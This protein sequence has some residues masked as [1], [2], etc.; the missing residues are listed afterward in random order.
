MLLSGDIE[1]I[2]EI[3]PAGFHISLRLR[4]GV[5]ISSVN[6]YPKIWV[7]KYNELGLLLYDPCIRWAF[8]NVGKCRWSSLNK[9]DSHN[10]LKLATQYDLKY[11]VVVSHKSDNPQELK[12]IAT[13]ARND[14]EFE[15]REL[16]YLERCV[17]RFHKDCEEPKKVTKAEIE[18]LELLA[19]GFLLKEIGNILDVSENAIKQRLHNVR[20]K[21]KVK[22]SVQAAL[23]A[24]Q[25]GII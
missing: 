22:T 23:R 20:R 1:H 15:E 9:C 16:S 24:H 21:L 25:F 7:D 17:Q 11:G 18:V 2:Y 14:R 3:A 5:P 6:N 13:F 4:Y 8:S 12:S 19:K 10:V